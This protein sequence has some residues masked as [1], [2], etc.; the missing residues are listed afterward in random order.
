M[1]R[2][3]TLEVELAEGQYL[4]VGPGSK[5]KGGN[6]IVVEVPDGYGAKIIQE[7]GG[8]VVEQAPAKTPEDIVNGNSKLE[9]VARVPKGEEGKIKIVDNGK[10]IKL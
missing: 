2:A 4:L 3:P 10:I 6:G 9:V 1:L 5:I 8:I 7:D